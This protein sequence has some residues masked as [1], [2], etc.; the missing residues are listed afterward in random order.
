M[1]A[2]DPASVPTL[3][4]SAVFLLERALAD[5]MTA[6]ERDRCLIDS[7]C[8]VSLVIGIEAFA[9]AFLAVADR[10]VLQP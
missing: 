8:A 10:V 6:A 3:R 7:L 4:F 2:I 5:D 1:T 9:Q